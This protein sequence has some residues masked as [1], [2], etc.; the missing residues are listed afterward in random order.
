MTGELMLGIP[1]VVQDAENVICFQVTVKQAY[2]DPAGSPDDVLV[3]LRILADKMGSDQNEC[4]HIALKQHLK[5]LFLAFAI[6]ARTAYDCRK[7]LLFK[8]RLEKMDALRLIQVACVRA[9]YADRGHGRVGHAPCECIGGIIVLL[10]HFHYFGPGLFGHIAGI[11]DDARNGCDADT[12]LAGNIIN[13][14]SGTLLCLMIPHHK[15]ISTHLCDFFIDNRITA[16]SGT[17]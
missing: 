7:L 6:I 10:D 5:V 13:V 1:V 15:L 8:K 16:V 11:V 14:H 9:Q 17:M 2:R 3:F 4:V 12:G